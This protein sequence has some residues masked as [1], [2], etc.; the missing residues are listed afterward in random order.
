MDSRTDVVM[1]ALKGNANQPSRSF[2]TEDRL[3]CM[4]F[5]MGMVCNLEM[6]CY[7]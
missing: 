6:L 2:A 3:Q 5:K 7:A 4:Y 1:S